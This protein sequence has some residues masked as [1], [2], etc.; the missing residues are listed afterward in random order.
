MSLVTP[1]IGSVRLN[2]LIMLSTT[3]LNDT[4]TVKLVIFSMKKELNVLNVSVK[5]LMLFVV[6]QQRT[7]MM[8]PTSR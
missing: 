4:V 2:V 1:F 6:E 8:S 3:N 5:L 7:V